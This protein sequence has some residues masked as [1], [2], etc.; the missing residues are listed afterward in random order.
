MSFVLA[1]FPL[2][3]PYEL[4]IRPNWSSYFNVF[5]LFAAVISLG[6]V[7]VSALLF[8]AAMASLNSMLRFDK[9]DGVFTYSAGAPIVPRRTLQFRLREIARLWVEKHD[10]T[11]G[12]PSYALMIQMSDGHKLRSGSSWSRREVEDIVRRLSTFLGMSAPV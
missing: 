1:F 2:L 8:W 11:D 5:F 7:A 12:A 6:A 3:A 9:D 10:W 4:V